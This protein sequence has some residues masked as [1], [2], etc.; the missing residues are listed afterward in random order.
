MVSD[1]EIL[2]LLQTEGDP[3]ELLLQKALEA[4]GTDN[5]TVLVV[6]YDDAP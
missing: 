6:V 2:R 3:A 1:E 4:G 5:I